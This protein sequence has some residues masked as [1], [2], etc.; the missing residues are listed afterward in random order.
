MFTEVRSRLQRVD[1]RFGLKDIPENIS[2]ADVDEL[3]LNVGAL[4]KQ[5]HQIVDT[6]IPSNNEACGVATNGMLLLRN[7][8]DKKR[9]EKDELQ[10]DFSEAQEE[11]KCIEHN[12]IQQKEQ[13]ETCQK[14]VTR[15]KAN[16]EKAKQKIVN[17]QAEMKQMKYFQ[18]VVDTETKFRLLADLQNLQTDHERDEIRLRQLKNERDKLQLQL[19]TLTKEQ[20]ALQ[21]VSNERQKELSEVTMTRNM[22]KEHQE[23]LSLHLQSLGGDPNIFNSISTFFKG[24][25]IRA[26]IDESS[27]AAKRSS[28]I[29]DKCQTGSSNAQQQRNIESS[30]E[31][32]MQQ[33]LDQDEQPEV[34][35]K[36]QPQQDKSER[37]TKYLDHSERPM[38]G[39]IVLGADT[40]SANPSS[41][42]FRKL[43]TIFKLGIS[44]GSN[45]D[46]ESNAYGMNKERE[47]EFTKDSDSISNISQLTDDGKW[48]EVSEESLKIVIQ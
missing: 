25:R 18:D 22:Y 9:A 38:V 30:C 15:M 36:Q 48:A 3:Q 21:F 5:L 27:G 20:D 2:Q 12:C 28:M 1:F 44:E 35:I 40:V 33:A 37:S 23:T 6:E 45:N 43:P 41:D 4:R 11:L 31:E 8:L 26:S 46:K 42:F 29:T 17:L 34:D 39:G 13:H 10:I 16:T 7:E 14:D 32:N 19:E 24:R 47:I